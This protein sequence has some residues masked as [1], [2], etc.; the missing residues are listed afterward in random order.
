MTQVLE[1]AVAVVEA[2]PHS[3][4]ALTLFALVSTMEFERAG[5]LFKLVKLRDLDARQRQIAY[6][7]MDLMADGR[8]GEAGWA[9]AKSHMESL[10][11]V[12]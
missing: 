11:R 10:I 2:A 4:A 9:A 12:G 1:E 6:G 5:C 7:L 3:A 8:A